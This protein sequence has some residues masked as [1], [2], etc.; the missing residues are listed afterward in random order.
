[1]GDLGQPQAAQG[2]AGGA[3]DRGGRGAGRAAADGEPGPGADREDV[4][5]AQGVV[6]DGGGADDRGGHRCDGGG[7]AAGVSGGHPALVPILWLVRAAWGAAPSSGPQGARSVP[8]LGLVRIWHGS[9]VT[10]FG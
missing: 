10:F 3:S 9:K 7:I 6:A 8:S 1:R 2:G 4:L 5:E